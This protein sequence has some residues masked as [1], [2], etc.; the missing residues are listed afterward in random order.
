MTVKVLH[1][2]GSLKLGGAQRV[3]LQNLAKQS[4][5]ADRVRFLGFVNNVAEVMNAFDIGYPYKNKY[6]IA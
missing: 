1:I 4:G 3:R 2:I 6:L 5:I